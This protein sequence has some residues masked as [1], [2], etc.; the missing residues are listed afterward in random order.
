M[1]RDADMSGEKLWAL[2]TGMAEKLTEMGEAAR[3]FAHPGAATRAAD[4][5][6]QVARD[7]H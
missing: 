7:F 6:E 1:V 2:A 3:K 5:L 4:I